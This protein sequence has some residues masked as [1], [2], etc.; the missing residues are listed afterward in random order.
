MVSIS[1]FGMTAGIMVI[2]NSQF[3]EQFCVDSIC[4][5]HEALFTH[6]I[7]CLAVVCIAVN[8]KMCCSQIQGWGPVFDGC[9]RRPNFC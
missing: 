2:F 4:I 1:I 7:V 8:I 6:M 9:P 3:L 5:V